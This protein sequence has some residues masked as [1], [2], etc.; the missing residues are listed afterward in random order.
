M[1]LRCWGTFFLWKII[2][3]SKKSF[4]RGYSESSSFSLS[5]IME[6]RSFCGEW[7]TVL[8]RYVFDL[9]CMFTMT[10]CAIH[11]ESVNMNMNSFLH[12]IVTKCELE[13]ITAI[14]RYSWAV[15]VLTNEKQTRHNHDSRAD[16]CAF[17][18][19]LFKTTGFIQTRTITWCRTI[20][21]F[22]KCNFLIF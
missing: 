21:H 19:I 6:W 4:A 11:R 3:L 22:W 9:Y 14:L 20:V 17:L 1:K 16:R 12:S 13:P 18:R 7:R 5:L 2:P 15:F 8:S 10:N